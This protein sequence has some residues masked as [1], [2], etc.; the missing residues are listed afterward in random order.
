MR[1]SILFW[2]FTIVYLLLAIV[3]K[4]VYSNLLPPPRTAPI[5]YALAFLA[6]MWTSYHTGRKIKDP[7]KV[8]L[9]IAV[10]VLVLSALGVWGLVVSLV[11]VGVTILIIHYEANVVAGNPENARKELRIILAIVVTAIFLTPV[12]AGCIPLLDPGARYSP[13]RLFY[14]SAGYFTVALISL[15]PDFRVFLLGELIA[16]VSTFRTIG[17]AVAIAYTLKLAQTGKLGRP[18]GK[19]KGYI[20]PGTI[21]TG[22]VLIFIIRYYATIQTYPNLHLSFVETLL[23]RP[24]VTYTV[25]ERL[26]EMGMPLGKRGILFSADPKGYVGSL[27]GRDV[28]Y[29]YTLFGQPAYDFGI[30]GLIEALF[31]GMA[32]A[33][34]ER[35]NPTAVLAVTFA[36]LMI[37]IGIDAFF[38]SAMAFFAYLSVEVDV[39]KRSH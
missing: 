13:L 21:A 24:W 17:L 14:L 8:R 12:L 15:K 27:F 6:L 39:W 3:S 9:Y 30:F 19:W 18:G 10:M 2:I 1:L 20:I 32:L 7:Y 16:I 35:R 5:L 28:G 31:L 29:T 4:S 11:I 22:V 38:L 33:D 36:I 25:Y 26:F 23:Y 37:P 34:A